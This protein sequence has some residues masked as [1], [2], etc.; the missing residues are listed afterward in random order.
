VPENRSIQVRGLTSQDTYNATYFDPVTGEKAALGRIQPLST[1][2]WKCSPPSG[3][4]HDW[5]LIL[6][7]AL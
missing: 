7:H 4:D 5:V 2:V 1:G 6:E 3:N